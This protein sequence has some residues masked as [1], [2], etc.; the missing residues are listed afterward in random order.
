VRDSAEK[1]IK[2]LILKIKIFFLSAAVLWRRSEIAGNFSE[3]TPLYHKNWLFDGF[4]PCSI[5]E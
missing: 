1:I 2:P 4:L 5:Q 3:S